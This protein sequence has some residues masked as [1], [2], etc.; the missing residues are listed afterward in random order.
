MESG[1]E[2]EALTRHDGVVPASPGG[3]GGGPSPS[4]PPPT[5]SG[6]RLVGVGNGRE[7]GGKWLNLL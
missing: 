5:I 2:E 4:R 1:V 6:S 3:R 7:A